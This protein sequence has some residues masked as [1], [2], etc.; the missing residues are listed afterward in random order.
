MRLLGE[1]FDQV[2][3]DRDD[4]AYFTASGGRLVSETSD[5]VR[6]AFDDWHIRAK[7]NRRGV[8]F[9]ACRRLLGDLAKRAGGK[10]LRA[11]AL[12]HAGS[13]VGDRHYSNDRDFGKLQRVARKLYQALNAAGM[14]ARVSGGSKLEKARRE[15]ARTN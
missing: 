13:D 6:Q 4:T 1:Y 5:A 14:F 15:S 9:Y 11:A 3:T 10:E 12:A 7:I 8:S 2:P